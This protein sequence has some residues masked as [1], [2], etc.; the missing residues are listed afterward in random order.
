MQAWRRMAGSYWAFLP[1]LLQW[2]RAAELSCD[3]AALL[4]VQDPKAVQGVMM[5][6][7]GGSVQTASRLNVDAFVAQALSYDAAARASPIGRQ[8]R[9]AQESGATHPLPVMR[10]LELERWASSGEYAR[11]LGLRGTPAEL[12]AA[13][14]LEDEVADRREVR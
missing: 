9:R 3:R 11:L 10:A 4:V 7:S 8:I 14:A 2:Q 5:K 6:L 12:T 1:R 13:A